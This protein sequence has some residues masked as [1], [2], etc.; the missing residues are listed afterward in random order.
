MKTLAP[1]DFKAVAAE[2]CFVYCY[3]R[4]KDSA[5]AKQGTPYY[6][7]ISKRAR[8]PIEP[9]DS[10]PVPAD[11]KF[12][13]LMRSELTWEQACEWERIY[14]KRY[15]RKCLGTGI[16]RNQNDGGEGNPNLSAEVKRLIGQKSGA[17]RVG[18]EFSASHRA[19]LSAALKG[20]PKS[21]EHAA[22]VGAALRGISRNPESIEKMRQTKTGQK[23]SA[24][25]IEARRRGMLG[26]VVTDQTRAKLSAALR[27]R[28]FSEETLQRM[29]DSAKR[30]K[31]PSEKTRAKLSAAGKGKPKSAEHV[32]AA[33]AAR[34]EAAAARRLAQG[35]TPEMYERQKLEAARARK[36]EYARRKAL[37]MKGVAAV[38]SF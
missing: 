4:S 25:H 15:G 19:N 31:P 1:V 30:R 16:L 5:T 20:V 22:A 33:A 35:I 27:G 24:D 28:T 37:E 17:A 2:G 3:L 10:C 11:R 29:S 34:K 13:R 8:R 6:V 12:I 26:H 36:R 38:Q 7:G 14:I 21:P 9:H 32:K 23:Q 18:I